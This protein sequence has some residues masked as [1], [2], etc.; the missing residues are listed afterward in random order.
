[1]PHAE[2]SR[3]TDANSPTAVHA[4]IRQQIMHNEIRPGSRIN[5]DKLARELGVSTTPVR[6]ALRQ[7]QGD[8]LVVQHPG[9]G[10]STTPLLNG[11]E[12]RA[13]FEFRLLVEPWAARTAAQERLSNPGYLLEQHLKG[14][15]EFAMTSKN[16]RQEVVAHDTFFHDSIVL[17][18]GNTVLSTAYQQAHCQLHSYRLHPHDYTY[19]LTFDE[20]LTIAQAIS[21]RDPQAAEAGMRAHLQNAYLR[22][23]RLHESAL[24]FPLREIPAEAQLTIEPERIRG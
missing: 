23:T 16:L 24:E 1:M 14:I 10:Y 17:S 8:N 20:H 3:S 4:R 7:L 11:E 19:R 22:F 13:M 18:T 21:N 12:L 5:V 15:E 6:E 9:R 2:S